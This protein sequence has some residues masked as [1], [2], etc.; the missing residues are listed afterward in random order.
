MAEKLRAARSR[1]EQRAATLDR[2]KEKLGVRKW[3]D[4]IPA[5]ERLQEA[6][7]DTT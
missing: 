2:I 4:I 1:A 6:K 7:D 3:T 5:I